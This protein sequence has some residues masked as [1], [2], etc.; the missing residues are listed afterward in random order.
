MTRD[1]QRLH[2]LAATL[3]TAALLI[4]AEAETIELYLNEADRMNSVGAILDPTLF[5]SSERRAAD[6]IMSPIVRAA[7]DYLR[8]YEMATAAGR[9]ALEKVGDAS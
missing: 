1:E 4:K 2:S 7:R 3:S 5:M 6:A 8:A 9:S